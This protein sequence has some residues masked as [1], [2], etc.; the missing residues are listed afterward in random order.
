MRTLI[1]LILLFSVIGGKQSYAQ[2]QPLPNFMLIVADDMGPQLEKYGH[3][4]ARTPTLDSLANQGVLFRNAQAPGST[5]SVARASIMTGTHPHTHNVRINVHEYMGPKP[6]FSSNELNLMQSQALPDSLATLVELLVKAG[7]RTGLTKKF[8]TA[9]HDRYPYHEWLKGDETSEVKAF[10]QR[11]GAKPWFLMVNVS[12][13]H[14]PFRLFQ[15]VGPTPNESVF[16]LPG[17]FPNTPVIKKD[18]T[19]YLKAIQRTDAEVGIAVNSVRQLNQANKTVII[20]VGD[21]GPPYHR[22]KYSTYGFGV[23]IPFIVSG[24]PDLVKKNPQGATSLV[25]LVDIMPTLLDYAGI[26]KPRG[27]QGVSLRPLLLGTAGA[28]THDYLFSEVHH[29]GGSPGS[30][31][32]ERS[33]FDGRFRLIFRDHLQKRYIVPGDNREVSPWG[34]PVYAEIIKRKGEFPAQYAMLAQRDSDLE[35]NAPMAEFYDTSTDPWEV[36]DLWN[37][38]NHNEDKN[39]LIRALADWGRETG[40][41]YLDYAKLGGTISIH[42]PKTFPGSEA[43]NGRTTSGFGITPLFEYQSEDG[44]LQ[45]RDSQGRSRI[46]ALLPQ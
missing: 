9:S 12:S 45:F 3:P 18:W 29:G 15:S 7:Y 44:S 4:G 13:P 6:N 38:Q 42:S 14:R 19:E 11:A 25:S 8:H 36:K 40:D 32:Q 1:L 23:N 24:P 37:S 22:G 35:G 34:N 46:P 20:F 28:K 31:L 21:H 33:I 30:A 39:R 16:K 27:V 41:R 5:C 10:I 43:L 26:A 17:H 2:T